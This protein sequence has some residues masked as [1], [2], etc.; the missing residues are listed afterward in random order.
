MIDVE[1]NAEASTLADRIAALD[2]D[3]RIAAACRGSANPA[4]LAWLAE[5][6]SIGPTSL[7]GD[8]GAGLGGPATWLNRRWQCPIVAVDP[9]PG[10]VAGARSL[11]GLDVV[12]A[13]ADQLPFPDAVFD[14]GLLL[15]VVSVVDGL[16]AVLREAGRVARRLGLLDYCSTSP[17]TLDAGG[18]TFRTPQGLVEALGAGGWDVDQIV[19]IDVPTPTPWARAADAAQNGVDMPSSEQEVAEAIESGLL[20]PRMVTARRRR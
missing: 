1:F 2:I 3:D 18:S 6:L 19:S 7:V 13:A 5:E 4:A 11:F 9:S 10:A 16:D 12:Q 8:L 17:A 14:I 20:V 15:G